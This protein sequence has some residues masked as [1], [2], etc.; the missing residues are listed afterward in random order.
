M[1]LALI[2]VLLV[3]LCFA[4][5]GTSGNAGF[6]GFNSVFEPTEAEKMF[7][8]VTYVGNKAIVLMQPR[9]VSAGKADQFFWSKDGK[10]LLAIT[11]ETT[12]TPGQFLSILN[13]DQIDPA[14]F[15]Q[16]KVVLWNSQTGSLTVPFTA[17]LDLDTIED[18]SWLPEVNIFGF[19]VNTVKPDEI[20]PTTGERISHSGEYDENIV[21]IDPGRNNVTTF[22]ALDDSSATNDLKRLAVQIAPNAYKIITKDGQRDVTLPNGFVA[23]HSQWA[24]GGVFWVYAEKT[25]ENGN[26][27]EK[28]FRLGNDGQ[29]TQSNDQYDPDDSPMAKEETPAS[30]FMAT[31]EKHKFDT[32]PALINSWWLYVGGANSPNRVLISPNASLAEV[33]PSMDK[34]AYTAEG[35]VFVRDIAVIPTQVAANGFRKRETEGATSAAKQLGLAVM[36]YVQDYDETYPPADPDNSTTAERLL[37]YLRT[38]IDGWVYTYHDGTLAEIERPAEVVIAYLPFKY[39]YIAIY[40]DGH[41]KY[42][43]TLPQ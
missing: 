26:K 6:T 35:A 7:D 5:V 20:D 36:Q 12:M 32:Q 23:N 4:A 34:V 25:L 9:L 41:V 13:G 40:A 15:T 1:R 18:G 27:V 33:S 24:K 2:T 8:S 22:Q 29:L 39:G 19:L 3:V 42:S 37:P 30:Y 11:E 17:R 14:K 16:R 31:E 43:E 38:P 21:L 28:Q 10:Y